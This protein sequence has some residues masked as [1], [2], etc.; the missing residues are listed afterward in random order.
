MLYEKIT[1]A[2]KEAMLA[3]DSLKRDCLRYALSDIKN[4]TVNAGKPI[5]DEA[6]LKVLKKLVK[7]HEDSIT[8]F[9]ENGRQDLAGKEKMELQALQSFLPEMLNREQTM[10]LVEQTIEDCGIARTKKSM[11]I[12]MKQLKAMDN[13]D[14]K[15]ASQCL[16]EI[17]VG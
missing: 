11:G 14:M 16:N 6:C 4:L 8:Q 10:A 9:T 17:L 2:V 7:Q 12:L 13:V 1:A 5:D 15:T 3:K